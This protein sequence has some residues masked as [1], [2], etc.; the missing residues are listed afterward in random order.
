MQMNSKTR[1][2]ITVREGAVEAVIDFVY[3]GSKMQ[4]DG[5]FK[6]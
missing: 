5:D 1:E 2:L 6:T 4:A 3:L